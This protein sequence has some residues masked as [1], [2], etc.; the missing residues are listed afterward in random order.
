MWLQFTVHVVLFPML[1]VFAFILLH[2]EVRMQ[3]PK[4]IN[5]LY[6]LDFAPPTYV[7]WVFF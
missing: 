7:P 1:N 5:S 3:C 2:P 4:S 6:F